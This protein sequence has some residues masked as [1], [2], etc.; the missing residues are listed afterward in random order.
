MAT[1]TCSSRSAGSG[2]WFADGSVP[3]VKDAFAGWM[4]YLSKPNDSP[5]I[6][7]AVSVSKPTLTALTPDRVAARVVSVYES[8]LARRARPVLTPDTA[9]GG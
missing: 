8:I 3:L 4:L 6:A 2:G 5:P 9:G 7:S 1:A